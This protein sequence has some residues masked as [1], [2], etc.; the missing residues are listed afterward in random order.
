MIQNTSEITYRLNNLNE[1]QRRISYQ[2]ST[3]K[4]LDDGSDDSQIFSREV[5]IQDKLNVYDGIQNQIV[6]TDAQNNASDSVMK[7]IKD[8]LTYAQ[9]EIIKARTDTSDST[10]REAIATN[11][12]GIKK[13][14]FALV[15]EEMEGEYLFAGS[16]STVKPFSMDTDGAVTYNGDGYLR[17]VAVEEGEYRDRGITGYDAIMY[18]SD[19]AYKGEKLSFD[20]SE[21]VIDQDGNEW[22]LSVTNSPA[23]GDGILTK[24]DPDG[25]PTTDTKNVTRTTDATDTSFAKYELT[26]PLTKNGE[27]LEAKHNIF[28]DLDNT[29]LALRGQ[30]SDGTAT[31]GDGE[32]KELLGDQLDNIK[33]AFDGANVGHA[34]LGGRNQVF[35]ISL[36]R[37]NSKITEFNILEQKVSGVDFGKLAVEAKALEITF[38]AMYSTINKMN[39]LTLVNYIN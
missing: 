27:V 13:N 39:Q 5:Y 30:K 21:R 35:D 25:N 2:N 37:V 18:S 22:K 8:L 28:D 4:I 34:K 16:N 17:Q 38:T 33:S 24:Y 31:S 3:G 19:T 26:D 11:F 1:E 32:T 15:N 6:K 9:A 23:S 12:E 29:I 36:E 7:E 10:S 14:L 20:T